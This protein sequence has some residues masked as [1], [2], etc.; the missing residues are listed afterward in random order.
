MKRILFVDD[1]PSVLQGLQRMLR[2]QRQEWEMEFAPNGEAALRLLEQHP[3]DVVVSDMRMPGMDGAK[4]LSEVTRRYPQTVRIIL[5]GQTDKEAIL[6]SVGPAHQFLAKPCDPDL[7]KETV[8]RACALRQLLHSEHL[9][10]LVSQVRSLPSLPHLY[11]QIQEELQSPNA[12]LQRVGQIIS[13]DIGMTAKVLQL[14]NSA[15]FGI[16]RRI[17][18]P[19]QAVALLGL[20]TVNAVVLS[21]KLF[22]SFDQALMGRAHLTTLWEHSMA[23]ARLAKR[24]TLAE[25][26]GP[27]LANYAFMGGL[28]HDAGKLVLATDLATAYREALALAEREQL[29]DWVAEQ[30]VLGAT[31]AEVGAYLL[32]LWGLPDPIVE[33]VAFHHHPDECAGRAFSALTAVHVANALD[34]ESRHTADAPARPYLCADYVAALGLTDRLPAWREMVGVAV[35]Q[36]SVP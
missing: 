21:V 24:I 14:V 19:A 11:V 36:T 18:Q 34:Q 25:P 12:S 13:Q 9:K 1:E 15:F 31:H 35:E 4:L 8:A 29:A 2:G 33:A 28:L 6:R 22:S 16:Q 17:T 32:G 23:T 26:D 10:G 27:R 30:R 5:S 20:E 3:V 7:L